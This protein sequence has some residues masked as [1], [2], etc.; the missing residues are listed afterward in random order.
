MEALRELAWS[1]IP[2]R[3]RPDCWRLLLGYAPP[4]RERRAAI[5]ARKRHEYRRVPCGGGGE[6]GKGSLR[7]R[8]GLGRMAPHALAQQ[9]S[10]EVYWAPGVQRPHRRVQEWDPTDSTGPFNPPSCLAETLCQTTTTAL[11]WR[12]PLRMKQGPSDRFGS[13]RV[14]RLCRHGVPPSRARVCDIDVEFSR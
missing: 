5:L 7:T 11:A 8:P 10:G 4:N 12:A 14:G 13:G 1:G 2:P 3:L 6:A 9:P